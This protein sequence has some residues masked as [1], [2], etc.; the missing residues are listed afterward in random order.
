MG[1]EAVFGD[2]LIGLI[3]EYSLTSQICSLVDYILRKN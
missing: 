2:K 1:Y 3:I